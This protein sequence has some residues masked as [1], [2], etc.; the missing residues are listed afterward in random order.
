MEKKIAVIDIGS[1]TIR[2]VIYRI[3][4]AGGIKQI[5]NMKVSARLQNHLD[6]RQFLSPEGIHI[7]LEAL[8]VFREIISLHKAASV[9]VFATAAIRKA[10]NRQEIKQKVKREIGLTINVLSGQKEAYFGFL[11]IIQSTNLD[12]GITIDIGGGST[13]ITRF[14]HKKIVN[15][16]SF[17]FGALSLKKEFIKGQLP[18]ADELRELSSF[19][20]RN[21]QEVEWLSNCRLP[22]IGI[23]GNARNVGTIEQ[24]MKN[25]PLGSVHLYE[26]GLKDILNVKEKLGSLPFQDLKGVE[27][28]SRERADI[29]LPAL[30]VFLSLYR[31]ASAPF[32]QLSQKGIRDGIIID[33]LNRKN[34][35]QDQL[36][37]VDQSL[38][39]LA[40]DYDMNVGKKELIVTTAA[41]LFGLFRKEGIA[42][43]S[44]GD[45][46]DLKRAGYVYNLGE[47]IDSESVSQ[48]TF[49]LL[50]N[51]NIDGLPHRE[52]IKIALLASYHS[53]ASFKQN[54]KPFKEWFS[55]QD[56][57]KMK[58]L[59]SLLK[60]SSAVNCTGR[61]IFRDIQLYMRNDEVHLELYCNGSWLVEQQEAEKHMKHLENALGKNISL[62]FSMQN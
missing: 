15:S 53:K 24:A 19:L 59:G 13:E 39:E 52:R 58:F 30:E 54:M 11:G 25:Y 23:G 60:F 7:L 49:Y 26:M 27:G 57:Q 20:Y 33:A 12:E 16:H 3:K 61:S 47:F 36:D 29:I 9:K 6:D 35:K 17:P 42:D 45:L 32:F 28:L 43:V 18:E 21:F 38:H 48:H 14:L 34:H 4:A 31:S 8:R 1:N 10:K 2:L 56:R 44:D 62:K 22:I 50:L 41:K 40:A 46:Q 55:E 5:E 37:P 51:R